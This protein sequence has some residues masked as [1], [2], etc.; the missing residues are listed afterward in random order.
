MNADMSDCMRSLI[1]ID[2]P[3]NI[4][5]RRF[6]QA[7]RSLMLS[8]SKLSATGRGVMKLRRT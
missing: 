5:C 4:A 8:A 6:V 7:S 2:W 1:V 3:R